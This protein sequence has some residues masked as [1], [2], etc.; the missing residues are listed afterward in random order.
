VDKS[1]RPTRAYEEPSIVFV[2]AVRAVTK[3]GSHGNICDGTPCDGTGWRR[4]SIVEFDHDH[5]ESEAT[6]PRDMPPDETSSQA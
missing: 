5:I 4:S 1:T 2:G 3:L 6:K